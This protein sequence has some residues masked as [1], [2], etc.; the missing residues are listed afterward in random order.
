M[1]AYFPS[2]CSRACL[3]PCSIHSIYFLACLSVA[4]HVSLPAVNTRKLVP[5]CFMLVCTKWC[6]AR[7]QYVV[8][9]VVPTA[10]RWCWVWCPSVVC[11]RHAVCVLSCLSVGLLD[12]FRQIF[13]RTGLL[14]DMRAGLQQI[15]DSWCLSALRSCVL[16]RGTAISGRLGAVCCKVRVPYIARHAPINTASAL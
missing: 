14:H 9:S 1:Y 16:V 11:A 8:S 10:V 4:R 7:C 13:S 2:V 6:V 12:A 5:V 15:R 3:S